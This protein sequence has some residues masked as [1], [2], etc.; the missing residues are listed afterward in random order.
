MFQVS[1]P[2]W[3]RTLRY[4][5]PGKDGLDQALVW[6]PMPKPTR[7]ELAV[8]VRPPR[9]A[10]TEENLAIRESLRRV[11]DLGVEACCEN[12]AK[13]QHVMDKHQ[14]SKQEAAAER[15]RD[16]SACI[17]QKPR[18]LFCTAGRPETLNPNTPKSRMLVRRA[19]QANTRWE[20][21]D[22][23]PGLGLGVWSLDCRI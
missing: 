14:I 3:G 21:R 16:T 8:R 2:C 4:E 9:L 5:A 12:K 11:A 22:L 23:R 7:T 10:Q 1:Y 13:T 15:S 18:T 17:P 6:G 20:H 19:L